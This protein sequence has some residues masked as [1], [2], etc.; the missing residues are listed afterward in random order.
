MGL[1][2]DLRAAGVEFGEVETDPFNYAEGKY[3]CFVSGV[4]E[5]TVKTE[6]NGEQKVIAFSYRFA[7]KEEGGEGYEG[8]YANKHVNDDK[9]LPNPKM[10]QEDAAAA[11]NSLGFVFQRFQQLG[12]EEPE[13][14]DGYGSLD[15]SDIEEAVMGTKLNVTLKKSKPKDGTEGRTFV[16]SV[17]VWEPPSMADMKMSDIAKGI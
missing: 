17:S 2:D 12:I 4:E 5:K 16:Q 8:R 11:M 3:I 9:W 7:T 6:K 15:T 14:D 1:F 13:G 10:F